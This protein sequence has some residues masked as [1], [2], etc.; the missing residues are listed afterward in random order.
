MTSNKKKISFL[1]TI[2]SISFFYLSI[3]K[4]CKIYSWSKSP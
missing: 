2:W 1:R 4:D 3:W